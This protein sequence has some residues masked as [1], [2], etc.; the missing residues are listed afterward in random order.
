MSKKIIVFVLPLAFWFAFFMIVTKGD[1]SASFF[2]WMALMYVCTLGII[3]FV[4]ILIYAI[5][6]TPRD[7]I[8]I[9]RNH[10][11]KQERRKNLRNLYRKGLIEDP[12]KT[13]LID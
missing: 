4:Y 9:F 6:E 12:E 7:I 11:R 5:R 2:F 13:G 3:L 1:V 8:S 10:K